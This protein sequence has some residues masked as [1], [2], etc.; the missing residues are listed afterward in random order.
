MSVKSSGGVFEVLRA[1][2]A[3]NAP[4][5]ASEL[6]AQLELPPSTAGRA[7][8]TLEAAG[9]ARRAPASPGKF[10]LGSA[11]QRLAYAFMSQY[12][13][14]D[15]AL[16]FLQELASMHGFSSSLFVRLG[17]YALR[18]AFFAGSN[19][20]IH[21][22][23]VG[24]VRALAD[25][26]AGKV[27]MAHDNLA[28]H[29]GTPAKG[30][31]AKPAVKLAQALQDVRVAG[32]ALESSALDQGGFD[33][34]FPLLDAQ[35]HSV[36]AVVLEGLPDCPGPGDERVLAWAAILRR[37]QSV[38]DEDPGL[39][40]SPYAHIDSTLIDLPDHRPGLNQPP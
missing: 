23:A 20:I 39:L 27:L 38:L 19:S 17:R 33:L 28:D 29:Q 2:A 10:E 36:A 30:T 26:A 37:L 18:I 24:E 1:L 35:G 25:G 11:G 31:A 16:P 9:F 13:I 3:A 4:L 14:R 21:I 15:A 12:P 7:A 22:N 5:G 34:A 40:L 8:A 6:A 32:W